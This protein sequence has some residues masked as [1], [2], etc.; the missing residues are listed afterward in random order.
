VNPDNRKESLHGNLDHK[1]PIGPHWD[2]TVR[3]VGGWR[4]Y[5]DGKVE[6]N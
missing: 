1:A 3:G 5:P 6:P 2:Q 4:I